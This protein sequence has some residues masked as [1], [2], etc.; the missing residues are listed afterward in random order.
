MALVMPAS[1]PAPPQPGATA[2]TTTAAPS[3]AAAQPSATPAGLVLARSLPVHLD[4][5]AIGVHSPLLQLGANPDNTVAGPPLEK[6]SKAG[7]FQ[8]SPTP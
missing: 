5:P 8:Y 7:W 3:A 1:E 6:D 2:P 4:V